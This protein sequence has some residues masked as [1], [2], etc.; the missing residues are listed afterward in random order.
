[1]KYIQYLVE[2]EPRKSKTTLAVMVQVVLVTEKEHWDCVSDSDWM[3]RGISKLSHCYY[4]IL[5]L[6]CWLYSVW[7]GWPLF[8]L[9]M[10]NVEFGP[11]RLCNM[12]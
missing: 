12:L 11:A 6:G 8:M 3:I 9:M 2:K 1:M 5:Q 4:N 7:S 10:N